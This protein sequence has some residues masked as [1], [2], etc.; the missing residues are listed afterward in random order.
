M[1][2]WRRLLRAW[3]GRPAGPTVNRIS[4]GE[5]HAPVIQAEMAKVTFR[6]LRP[7]P[8]EWALELAAQVFR[9]EGAECRRLLGHAD[10]RLNLGYTRVAQPG[11]EASNAGPTGRQTADAEGVADIVRYY[12]RLDPGRL[13]ITGAAGAGKTVLAMELMI[14]LLERREADD[15]VPVRIPLADWPS[16]VGLTDFVKDVLHKT[17][18]WSERRAR[19]LVES[20]WVLPVLDGLDEMDPPRANGKP[21]PAALRARAALRAI[22]AYHR[23]LRPGPVILTCRDDAYNVLA[24]GRGSA[25]SSRLLDAAQV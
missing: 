11:R 4:G 17:Y 1:E 7:G 2:R 13:V 22:N 23:G 3:H 18:R 12:R 10:K 15:P 19:R 16:G 20:G 21:D 9:L 14:A 6:N 5:F 8:R 24:A 25:E